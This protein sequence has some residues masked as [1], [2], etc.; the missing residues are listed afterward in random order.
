M[1][2]SR[3]VAEFVEAYS[4]TSNDQLN[5]LVGTI[6]QS[7][8]PSQAP[9]GVPSKGTRCSVFG[10]RNS[11]FGIRS[12]EGESEGEE[13]LE[14]GFLEFWEAYPK[15]QAKQAACKAWKRLRLGEELKAAIMTALEQHKASPQWTKDGGAYIPYPA[16][17]LNGRRWEDEAVASVSEPPDP[18]A[19]Y[20]AK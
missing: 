5:E 4:L 10:I 7:E 1:P 15:K 12:S 2:R 13:N 16:T 3:L 14:A 17:W 18:W 6:E 9:P 11:E 20:G 19:A 8:A